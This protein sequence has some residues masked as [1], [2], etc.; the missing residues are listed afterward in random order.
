M[1]ERFM[2]CLTALVVLASCAP[3]AIT[4]PIS[5]QAQTITPHPTITPTSTSTP[6]PMYVR[7]IKVSPEDMDGLRL[8]INEIIS[9]KNA[10]FGI[11]I[12]DF[13]NQDTLFIQ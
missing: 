3:R 2:V 5:A 7:T 6:K 12:Y 8:R 10:T 9:T 13:E 4:T 11:G 1:Y